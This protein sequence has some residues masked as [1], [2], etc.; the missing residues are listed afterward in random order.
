[1][2]ALYGLELTPP[3]L[4]MLYTT[5]HAPVCLFFPQQLTAFHL[6]NLEQLMVQ[7][8]LQVNIGIQTEAAKV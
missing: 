8:L 5:S 2:E 4:H 6:T 1:M 3:S 7:Y